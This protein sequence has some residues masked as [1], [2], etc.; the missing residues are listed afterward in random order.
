MV[1]QHKDALHESVSYNG[2]IVKGKGS[3]HGKR[4][5]NR[6]CPMVA[7][8]EVHIFNFYVSSLARSSIKL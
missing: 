3:K 4:D 7:E 2:R 1:G 6:R 8:A 5:Q